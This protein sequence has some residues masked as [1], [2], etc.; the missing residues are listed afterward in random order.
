[1]YKILVSDN[2]SREGLALLEAEE[3]FQVDVRTGM[4]KEELKAVIGE[5]DAIIIR[6]GTK[7][8]RDIIEAADGL[9][10]IGR[11]GVGLDNVDVEAATQK[12]II[13]M[14]AP[15]G[16]TIS[17]AEHTVSLLLALARNI[18][19]AHASLRKGE[20]DRKRFMGVELYGKTLGIIGLGRIGSEVAKRLAGFGMR[21]IVYDPYANPEAAKRVNAEL[22]D[23]DTLLGEA[24]FITLHVP[25]TSETHHMISDKEFEKMKDGVRIVNAAR[26]GVVDEG[27]LLRAIKS[28]KVAGAALDVYE[29]E[30]PKDNPLLELDCVVTTPHLGASTRE[31]QVNV[32]RDIAKQVVDALKY[33]I[34]RNA[35][36]APMV[37]PEVMEQIKPFVDLAERMGRLQGQ[38]LK[39][40]AREIHL[41][42]SGEVLN[43]DVTPITTAFLK[44][45]LSV[46]VGDAVNFVNAPL[47]AQQRQIR[48]VESKISSCEDYL[49]LITSEIE[50]DSP[51][52]LLSGTVFGKKE[53]RIVRIGDYMVNAEP[54]GNILICYHEDKPG[55]VGKIG[56]ILGKHGVNIAAMTLGRKI[57][58][59]TE[60]TVL[61]LDSPPSAEVVEEIKGIPEIQDILSANL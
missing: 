25:L 12:G 60:I 57:K 40:A 16:N 19:Q 18:P 42:Y 27:A 26:G 47:V 23:L 49:S 55:V 5:Y 48:V 24:D 44:G 22:V 15:E 38:L 4:S 53:A 61:N 46:W 3:D 39:G 11:A 20:W 7:L 14:N 43:L 56:T 45:M 35:V 9:K 17:T 10:V 30:P 2:L 31:A 21:I 36:N 28:G 29:K 8:T 41:I 1:M 6:S 52:R 58:G 51:A 50:T 59:G 32:A 33:G 54:F 34:L 13:V 37:P